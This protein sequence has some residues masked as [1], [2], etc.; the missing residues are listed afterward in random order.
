M[1]NGLEGL[2]GI[3]GV[4]MG[5]VLACSTWNLE[6]E[7]GSEMINGERDDQYIVKDEVGIRPFDRKTR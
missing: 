7:I 1:G 6:M 4:R 2:D 5:K 3:E